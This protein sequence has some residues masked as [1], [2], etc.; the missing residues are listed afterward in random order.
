MCAESIGGAPNGADLLK[1]TE[2]K[3]A[4]EVSVEQVAG[5]MEKIVGIHR[6][7]LLDELQA[8]EKRMEK[9]PYLNDRAGVRE[10]FARLRE[11][12]DR[13]A[14]P[15]NKEQS[16]EQK[17]EN[18]V[19]MLLDVA[20]EKMR[21]RLYE[22]NM[23]LRGQEEVAGLRQAAMAEMEKMKIGNEDLTLLVELEAKLRKLGADPRSLITDVIQAKDTLVEQYGKQLETLFKTARKALDDIDLE[24]VEKQEKVI[25]E[26]KN[27]LDKMEEIKRRFNSLLGGQ[28]LGEFVFMVKDATVENCPEDQLTT[29][30]SDVNRLLSKVGY[31]VITKEEIF[32]EHQ[33][34]KGG[35]ER[36]ELYRL[37]RRENAK[38]PGDS[39]KET[40]NIIGW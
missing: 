38:N 8:I 5:M 35:R 11:L 21:R 25:G 32:A 34:L 36:P 10:T 7:V 33:R 1:E 31:H 30:I 28:V 29:L 37:F 19:I 16:P 27:G 9:F 3:E 18:M 15:E 6:G 39:G 26:F 12:C 20:I 24:D 14:A 2:G 4:K 13:L 17:L 40:G 23:A 22:W